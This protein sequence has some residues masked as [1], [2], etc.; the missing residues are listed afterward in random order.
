MAQH[1]LGRDL[2][3]IA[4][5]VNVANVEL[6]QTGN[7]VKGQPIK[8]NIVP[9]ELVPLDLC[10]GAGQKCP[11]AVHHGLWLT[12]ASRRQQEK[13]EIVAMAGSRFALAIARRKLFDRRDSRSCQIVCYR[14]Y[15]WL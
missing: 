12:R 8:R 6:H 11:M 3:F 4:T 14:I 9:A 1:P 7:V 15:S 13:R 2:D 10:R 5:Q